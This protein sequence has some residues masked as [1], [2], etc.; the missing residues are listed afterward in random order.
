M[1]SIAISFPSGLSPEK[2]V[3]IQAKRD[4]FSPVNDEVI[5][6]KSYLFDNMW[7][8]KIDKNRSY[9]TGLRMIFIGIQK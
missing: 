5:F 6:L 9:Q 7:L 2:L 4:I 1:D 3:T 8:T